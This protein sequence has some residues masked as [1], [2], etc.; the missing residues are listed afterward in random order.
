M[1]MK[2]L[3]ILLILNLNMK[4]LIYVYIIVDLMKDLRKCILNQLYHVIMNH[5]VTPIHYQLQRL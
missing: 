2:L 5:G 4:I 1:K 3:K